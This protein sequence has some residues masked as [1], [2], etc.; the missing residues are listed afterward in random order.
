VTPS[1]LEGARGPRGDARRS[2]GGFALEV[3]GKRLFEHAIQPLPFSRRDRASPA[4]KRS[5]ED[6]SDL[7]LPDRRFI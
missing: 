7:G 5:I 1:Q 3:F 2:S 4:Q 6:G